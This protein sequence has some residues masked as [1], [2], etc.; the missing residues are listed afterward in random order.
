M[1]ERAVYRA[2]IS[3]DRQDAL[4][5]ALNYLWEMKVISDLFISEEK[6]G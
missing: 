3:T 1:G 5:N 6:S 4:L 2:L